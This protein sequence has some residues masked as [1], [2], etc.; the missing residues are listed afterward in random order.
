MLYFDRIDVSRRID[1]DQA[2]ASKECDT[3]HYWYFLSY[4]FKVQTYLQKI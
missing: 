2:N 1:V 3:C 4:C